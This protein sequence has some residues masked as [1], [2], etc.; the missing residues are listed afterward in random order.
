M[1][2]SFFSAKAKKRPTGAGKSGLFSEEEIPESKRPR[3]SPAPFSGGLEEGS[4][5]GTQF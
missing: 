3:V 5:R 1:N 4:V 2:C